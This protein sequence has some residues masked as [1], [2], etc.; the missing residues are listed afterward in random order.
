MDTTR[1][2][3]KRERLDTA[4]SLGKVDRPPALGGWIADPA[5]IM[6]LTGVT[7]DEYWKDPV[8]ISIAAYKKLNLDGLLDVNV[9]AERGIYTCIS[10]SVRHERDR[11]DS[12]EAI[13]AEIEKLPGAEE[14]RATFDEQAYY[15]ETLAQMQRMQALCGEDLYWCPARWEVIPN[16]EMFQVAS[17]ENYLIAMRFYPEKICQFMDHQAALAECKARVL[18]RLVREGLHPRAMLCGKDICGQQG[19][20]MDP[21]FFREQ[22]FPRMRQAIEP[23][24]EVG[25]KLVYHCD[26]DVRMFIDDLIN[27]GVGG[28]QGFQRECGVLLEDVVERRTIDGDPLLIFGPISVTTTL[29]QETPRGIKKEVHRAIKICE[30]K[31]HLVLFTSNELL[32]DVPLEN[33]VAMY[34]AL[35]EL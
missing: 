10:H 5:K 32:P 25:A 29:V 23:L 28:L 22:F 13:V 8:S 27:T 17:V 1:T 11:Y 19:P 16:W 15:D 35:L 24:R 3:T 30:G 21:S 12:P 6:T 9:P 4:F 26:G 31:A 2:F 34:D 33:M 14:T 20:I 18:A 7:E